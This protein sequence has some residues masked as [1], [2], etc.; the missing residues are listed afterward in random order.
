MSG[1]FYLASPMRGQLLYNGAMFLKVARVLREQGYL[2]VSPWEH[3]IENGM[4]PGK[5]LGEQRFDMYAAFKWDFTKILGS[6][7]VVL[8]P[9]WRQSKGVNAELV[10]ATHAGIP[11]FEWNDEKEC[12]RPLRMHPDK[13]RIKWARK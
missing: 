10:V 4:D 8:L 7:G 11:V 3:D 9:G 6:K 1:Y 2:V 5:S 13:A 12:I